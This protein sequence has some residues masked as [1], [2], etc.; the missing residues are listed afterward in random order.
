MII[1]HLIHF[2]QADFCFFVTLDD[3]C[4]ITTDNKLLVCTQSRKFEEKK[5]KCCAIEQKLFQPRKDKAVVKLVCVFLTFL[6]SNLEK[7]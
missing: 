5:H 6:C 3:Y 7:D 2:D 1:V 4:I